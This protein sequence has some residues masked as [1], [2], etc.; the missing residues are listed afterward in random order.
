MS[1]SQV[2]TLYVLLA[3]AAASIGQEQDYV[4]IGQAAVSGFR[5]ATLAAHARYAKEE[6]RLLTYGLANARIFVKAA[7]DGKVTMQDFNR[8][9]FVLPI[10][11]RAWSFTPLDV[12][13]DFSVGQIY[14][15]IWEQTTAELGDK[16]RKGAALQD[17]YR[18]WGRAEYQKQNCELIGK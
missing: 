10:V 13:V 4:K 14:E 5:C 11:L 18:Q 6:N 3:Y 17:D 16:T 8:S 9:E 7:R 12:P 15:S 2:L 1:N